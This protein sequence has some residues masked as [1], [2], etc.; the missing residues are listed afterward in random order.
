MLGAAIIG[1][2]NPVSNVSSQTIWQKT[3]PP[4]LMGRV[5][6]VRTTVAWISIPLSMVLAGILAEQIGVTTLLF[7]CAV[8]GIAALT[9]AWFMTELPNV[10]SILAS[11][12]GAP[13]PMPAPSEDANV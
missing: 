13:S 5:M 11:P 10:E 12:E 1:V 2:T 3:V 8:L 7:T 4:E 9:Y 6:S